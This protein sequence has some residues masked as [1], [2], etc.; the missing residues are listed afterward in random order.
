MFIFL[1]LNNRWLCILN[2]PFLLRIFLFKQACK[3]CFF[4]LNH[5]SLNRLK[6][7]TNILK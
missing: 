4:L 2:F 5:P 7:T 6:R 1:L 3:V